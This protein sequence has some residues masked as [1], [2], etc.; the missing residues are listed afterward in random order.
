MDLFNDVRRFVCAVWQH[1]NM[2]VIKLIIP[3]IYHTILS[4]TY[5]ICHMTFM[6]GSSIKEVVRVDVEMSILSTNNQ[7]FL[8]NILSY[9]PYTP[10]TECHC[11]FPFIFRIVRCLMNVKCRMGN[12]TRVQLKRKTLLI[13]STRLFHE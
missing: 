13:A 1:D 10:R 8:P 5:G 11:L 9:F 3:Y 4:R 2:A 6:T 12:T 7:L